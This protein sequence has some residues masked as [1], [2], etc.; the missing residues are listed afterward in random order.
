MLIIYPGQR[1]IFERDFVLYVFNH[2]N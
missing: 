2:V 1:H